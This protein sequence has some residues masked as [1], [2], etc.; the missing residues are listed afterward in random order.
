MWVTAVSTPVR[1][2]DIGDRR[3]GIF[4]LGSESGYQRVLSFNGHYLGATFFSYADDVL[5]HDAPQS[6]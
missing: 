5:G 6:D 3:G 1:H 2:P 4:M